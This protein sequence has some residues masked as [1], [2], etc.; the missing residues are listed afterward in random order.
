VTDAHVPGR[1]LQTG[2]AVARILITWA[3]GTGALFALDSRLSGFAMRSWWQPP[4]AALL[5]G[6]LTAAVWPLVLRVALPVAFFTFGL[7][8]FLLLGAGVLGVFAAIPGV[9]VRSLATSVVVAVAMAA[10]SGAVNSLLAVNDDELFFRRARRRARRTDGAGPTPPGVLFLQIDGLAYDTARRAVRDGSMPTLAGWLRSGSHALTSW[11]TDWSSQT[12]AAVCGILHGSTYDILGFRW[13]EKDTDHVVRVSHPADA[14]E[15]ER[16]H[17]DGRGLLSG[18]GAGRG[19]LFTGD[20]AHVS[21]T[22]SSVAHLV[23][24]RSRRARTGRDRVGAGY[25]AYFANPANA[26]R[27]VGVCLVD[28]YRELRAAAQQRRA[29][30]RPRVP[31]GGLYPLARPGT[32]VIARDVVVSALLEDM[33]AGR[34]VVYADF[35]GYDEV[36][37]HSGLERFDTLEV[38]R[39]IDQQIGRLYRA[40]QLAPRQYHLVCLSDHGQT[41]GWAF[42]DRF[43]ESVEQLVGRLCGGSPARPHVSGPKDSRRPVE[44][45]QVGAGL[46]EGSGPIARRLR[47]RAEQAGAVRHDHDLPGQEGQVPRVAPGVVCVVSGHVAMVSFPDIPGRVSIEEIERHWPDLL[48]GLV[49]H[50]GVGFLLVHSEEFGPVALGRD[51][52]RRLASGVVIGTDPLLDY[53]EHAAALVARTSEF[54]H[55]PDVVI[56]SRY[57]PHT[58]EASPFE[59]HV[60]S[61]GGLG[62]P[63]QRGFLAYP[64]SFPAPGEVVGAEAL[65]RVL[66]GWLTDLGHPEPTGDG[67]VVGP[68]SPTGLATTPSYSA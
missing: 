23:P 31:R 20:A 45:W 19:N 65:H 42:A 16:Q 68:Q 67:A 57:D 60:G 35:L 9:E 41:Q 52:L 49:D 54:P 13:Y 6:L 62:G 4:V 29:D 48:P 18:G 7:G 38:L 53:G 59:P 32:T 28:I 2:R 15:V 25:Y 27:T 39:T 55:C 5:L 46:A 21:L 3:A 64:R 30:V 47:R 1:L 66:R 36:A 33:L 24:R 58:D 22:M 61:H 11:H 50:A 44:G 43:G 14:V 56:N 12:G 63:Q 34:P 8:G 26:V 51:G 17:A 40:T 37:H 10:V